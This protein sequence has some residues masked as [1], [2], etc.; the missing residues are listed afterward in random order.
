MRTFQKRRYPVLTI[1][2]PLHL[3][4]MERNR[5]V[6]EGAVASLDRMRW[7]RFRMRGPWKCAT[8]QPISASQVRVSASTVDSLKEVTFLS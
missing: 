2:Y 5:T 6:A 1:C 7:S 8:C 3:R 4:A